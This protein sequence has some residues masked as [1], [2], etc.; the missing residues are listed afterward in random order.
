MDEFDPRRFENLRQAWQ[1]REGPL[2]DLKAELPVI[3]GPGRN[4]KSLRDFIKDM[5]ALA[6]TARR[7]DEPAYIFY[8]V[9]DDSE[10]VGIRGQ[11]IQSPLPEDWASYW[12]VTSSF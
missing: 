9:K 12:T 4:L 2:R 10:I 6:N 8:G 11:C 1:F 7:R 5:I 3:A